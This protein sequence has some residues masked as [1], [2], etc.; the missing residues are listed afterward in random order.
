M[1][2]YI[3]KQN[4]HQLF[5]ITIF[6]GKDPYFYWYSLTNAV[7]GG[8]VRIRTSMYTGSIEDVTTSTT[9]R[10]TIMVTSNRILRWITSYAL[11][12]DTCTPTK[13]KHFCF[14]QLFS[15]NFFMKTKNANK[16]MYNWNC[17]EL[18][19]F[20]STG[21]SLPYLYYIFH[22]CKKSSAWWDVVIK[23]MVYL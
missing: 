10:W 7:N 17:Y 23:M 13:N 21:C 18:E 8:S 1:F 11:K 22:I 16:A 2:T 19:S 3:C 20:K 4:E 6:R 9:F 5:I 12:L 15:S 14:H